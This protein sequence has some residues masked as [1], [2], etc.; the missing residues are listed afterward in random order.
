MEIIHHHVIVKVLR[1]FLKVE[2]K[3]ERGV[4]ERCEREEESWEIFGIFQVTCGG[5]P[6]EVIPKFSWKTTGKGYWK[7]VGR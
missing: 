4:G 1:V 7:R 2:G 6:P 5:P 3:G